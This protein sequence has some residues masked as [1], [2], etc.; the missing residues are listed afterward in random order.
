MTCARSQP[1]CLHD[2]NCLQDVA[3]LAQNYCTQVHGKLPIKPPSSDSSGLYSYCDQKCKCVTTKGQNEHPPGHYV[4]PGPSCDG[5]C[6]GA[7][8][9]PLHSIKHGVF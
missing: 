8:C 3:N 5:G 4:Y 6:Y 7:K 2:N 1:F 9:K